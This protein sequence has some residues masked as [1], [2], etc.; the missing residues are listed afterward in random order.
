MI[1]NGDF[2]QRLQVR[3]NCCIAYERYT[4]R[5]SAATQ[6][7]RAL[8]MKLQQRCIY[9]GKITKGS[10]KRIT[11][12]VNL[13]V[14]YAPHRR[15][16]N[17]F[18]GYEVPHHLSFITLTIS[19]N[20]RNLTGKEAYEKLLKPMLHYLRSQCGMRSYIWKLELQKRGQVHYHITTPTFISHVQI[21]NK[22]NQLQRTTG[23]LDDFYGRYGHC[24]PNSTDIHSVYKV[25]DLT[26]YLIKYIAKAEIEKDGTE[27]KVWDC[28]TDLKGASY[29][30]FEIDD[31]QNKMLST[32]QASNL[33]TQV[34][35]DR[36]SILKV[37]G[38]PGKELLSQQH[39]EQYPSF[40]PLGR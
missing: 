40:N 9:S 19:D 21:R 32:L 39:Y 4:G 18:L 8:N 16:F 20:T 34:Q 30:D 29:P 3:S 11:K 10:Q 33:L 2:E 27:G 7:R 5:P 26:S 25:D 6:L 35:R 17:E 13:L 12:A 36:I 1:I 31:Q 22:W 37:Q 38:H 24:D 28:S 15:V 23:L 14:M